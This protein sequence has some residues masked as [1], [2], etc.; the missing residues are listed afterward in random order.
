MRA[1]THC[2]A[3]SHGYPRPSPGAATPREDANYAVPDDS[4][5]PLPYTSGRR[6]TLWKRRLCTPK[7]LF[8]Q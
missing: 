8:R 3:S 4:L 7:G 1:L 2:T 6:V 5:P